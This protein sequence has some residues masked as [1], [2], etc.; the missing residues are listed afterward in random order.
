MELVNCPLFRSELRE[1]P[2]Q[3]IA[4]WEKR[5]PAAECI[6]CPKLSPTADAGPSRL[7][8]ACVA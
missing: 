2:H 7:P 8:A 5:A 6:T 1:R 3:T 4:R